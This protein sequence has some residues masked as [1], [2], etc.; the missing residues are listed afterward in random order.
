MMK[1][2]GHL[3]VFGPGDEYVFYDIYKC[4]MC[5]Y[6]EKVIVEEGMRKSV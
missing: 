2:N 4:P 3:S 6:E 1:K 5:K